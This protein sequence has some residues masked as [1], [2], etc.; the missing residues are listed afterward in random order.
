MMEKAFLPFYHSLYYLHSFSGSIHIP[1][2]HSPAYLLIFVRAYHQFV[3]P[4]PFVAV[5]V[6]APGTC[7]W[8][9]HHH[10][11]FPTTTTASPFF[12]YRFVRAG[13]FP[14]YHHTPP[15][16]AVQLPH[17][18]PQFLHAPGTY[19]HFALFLFV[20]SSFA[21]VVF[22]PPPITGIL[23]LH[24]FSAAACRRCNA[25]SLRINHAV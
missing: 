14:F 5:L 12:P 22:S 25:R 10:L 24:A 6:S 21:T 11:L 23:L 1:L 9:P 19:C 13:T 2:H 20:V 8:D 4:Q 16:C 17:T 3:T 7:G 18:P 15:A